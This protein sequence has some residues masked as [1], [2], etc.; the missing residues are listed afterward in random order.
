MWAEE[1]RTNL[2]VQSANMTI[3]DWATAIGGGTSATT[4]NVS[5]VT[6]PDGTTT[7]SL[8][9]ITNANFARLTAGAA[10]AFGTGANTVTNSVYIRY[11]SGEA[12]IRLAMRQ[13]TSGTT[14]A[15]LVFDTQTGAVTSSTGTYTL[16]NAG[17]GWWRASVTG[18]ASGGS[19]FWITDYLYNG[20]NQTSAF[21]VWGGQVE[22]GAFPSSYIP[23]AGSAVTRTADS[24]LCDGVDFSTWYNSAAGTFFAEGSSAATDNSN[25]RTLLEAGVVASS[26][27][28]FG[29]RTI[30]QSGGV[31]TAGL[32]VAGGVVQAGQ[33]PMPTVPTR[34]AYA[35][36]TNDAVCAANAGL[37]ISTQ[38]V[39]VTMPACT[40]LR[41]GARAAFNDES[42][43]G[44]IRRVLY[45]NT[46]LHNATLQALTA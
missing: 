35:A 33:L 13:G 5:E 24:A 20:V 29:V 16:E 15:T 41:I 6:N 19:S 32:I 2:V 14:V 36:Q 28:R 8:F 21:Y 18:A 4:T 39:S 9:T 37:G 30:A 1:Q 7:Q 45:W 23:T 34:V 31:Q 11:K 22:A 26:A 38:D 42:L 3:G 10:A 17:N 27:E 12:R 44:R 43:N 25:A 40:A 46:R